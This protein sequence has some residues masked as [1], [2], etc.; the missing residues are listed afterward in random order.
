MPEKILMNLPPPTFLNTVGPPPPLIVSKVENTL[1]NLPN[2]TIFVKPAP[3][4]ILLSGKQPQQL[5]QKNHFVTKT[6]G[7]VKTE[8]INKP[9]RCKNVNKSIQN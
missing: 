6:G 2:R 8:A 7:Q 5:T 9:N 1:V 3:N 4:T